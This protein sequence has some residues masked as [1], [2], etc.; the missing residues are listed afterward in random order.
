MLFPALAYGGSPESKTCSWLPSHFGEVM[1]NTGES[2]TLLRGQLF[3]GISVDRKGPCKFFPVCGL[4]SFPNVLV[5]VLGAWSLWVIVRARRL[6]FPTNAHDNPF[7]LSFLLEAMLQ[8]R[9]NSCSSVSPFVS[10]VPFCPSFSPRFLFF[11]G[12]RLFAFSPPSSSS[13]CLS[14]LLLLLCLS[15]IQSTPVVLLFFPSSSSSFP[16][17]SPMIVSGVSPPGTTALGCLGDQ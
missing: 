4:W 12:G 14:H 3:L 15:L 13:L 10:S 7:S 17:H 6:W 8:G 16:E 2:W 5:C 1:V 11:H 9:S